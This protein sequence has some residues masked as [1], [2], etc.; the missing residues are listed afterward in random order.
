[1]ATGTQLPRGWQFESYVP[2]AKDGWYLDTGGTY[3]YG[4]AGGFAV[5]RTELVGRVGLLRTERFNALTTPGY[6]SL[7]VGLGF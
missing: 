7:G 3:H 5:G 2:D 6:V 4:L 1:M